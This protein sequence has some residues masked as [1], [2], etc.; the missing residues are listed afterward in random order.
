MLTVHGQGCSLPDFDLPVSAREMAIKTSWGT[1]CETDAKRAALSHWLDAGPRSDTADAGE[2]V[3]QNVRTM[4]ASRPGRRLIAESSA[5]SCIEFRPRQSILGILPIPYP[6]PGFDMLTG[7][8]FR[9]GYQ[10]FLMTMFAGRWRQFPGRVSRQFSAEMSRARL[11]RVSISVL[12]CSLSRSK[13]RA[14]AKGADVLGISAPCC[15]LRDI[16]A[17]VAYLLSDPGS[18]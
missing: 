18:I 5:L 7:G 9:F 8:G 14:P 2:M 12:F 13:V 1:P 16:S 11:S 15:S 3:V 4:A 17:I 10:R 6:V